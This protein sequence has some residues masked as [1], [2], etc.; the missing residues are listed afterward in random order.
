MKASSSNLP[1]IVCT[2]CKCRPNSKKL[3]TKRCTKILKISENCESFKY[4]IKELQTDQINYLTKIDELRTNGYLCK[5][6]HVKYNRKCEVSDLKLES[7]D[8]LERI[9]KKS[10]SRIDECNSKLDVFTSVAEQLK[11]SGIENCCVKCNKSLHPN[12]VLPSLLRNVSVDYANTLPHSSPIAGQESTDELH[13]SMTDEN[14]TIY[15][16]LG[17]IKVYGSAAHSFNLKRTLT[18]NKLCIKQFMKILKLV[19]QHKACC[20]SCVDMVEASLKALDNILIGKMRNVY[21]FKKFESNHALK[22]NLE[23]IDADVYK[24][25]LF[26]ALD[27]IKRAATENRCYDCSADLKDCVINVSIVED[28]EQRIIRAIESI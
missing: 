28:L 3:T 17:S 26:D 27:R 1:L 8:E 6:C 15:E 22:F 10:V 5:S 12:R 13:F 2:F 24:S 23:Y 20:K 9:L 25:L 11:D 18:L 14:Y 21:Q 4:E 7:T 16:Y 19:K